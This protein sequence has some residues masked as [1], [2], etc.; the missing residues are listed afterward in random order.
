MS[1][2]GE[3]SEKYDDGDDGDDEDTGESHVGGFSSGG[4]NPSTFTA[5]TTPLVF[6]S[7]FFP[8][9]VPMEWKEIEDHMEFDD[10]DLEAYGLAVSEETEENGANTGED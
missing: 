3:E 1:G 4:T 9:P 2:E 8:W 6:D 10:E 5:G 7:V